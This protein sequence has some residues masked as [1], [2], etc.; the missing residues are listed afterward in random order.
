MSFPVVLVLLVDLSLL[1]VLAALFHLVDL[2]D[3]CHLVDLV[4]L[5]S[6]VDLVDLFHRV[7]GSGK[8]IG[9]GDGMTGSTGYTGLKNL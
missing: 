7:W 2:V 8:G 9:E 6:L 5:Y 4:D 1:V 3:L